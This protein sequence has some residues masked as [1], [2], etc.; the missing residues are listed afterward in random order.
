MQ[1]IDIFSYN[2]KFLG[3]FCDIEGA[4]FEYFE[5]NDNNREHIE[6]ANP[7]IKYEITFLTLQFI[8]ILSNILQ[9]TIV[10]NVL[11]NTNSMFNDNQHSYLSFKI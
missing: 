1:I 3:M 7:N 4:T 10:I 8:I 2:M 11:M 5:N 6:I 9:V